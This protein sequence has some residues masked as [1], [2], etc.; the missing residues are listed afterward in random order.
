MSKL[1]AGV[2]AAAVILTLGACSAETE[3]T[4]ES[5]TWTI[6]T[7][8]IA[9]TNLEPYMMEDLDELGQAG[10]SDALNLV[11][12]VDRSADYGD[13]PVLGLDGWVGGKLLELSD[14]GAT[15]LEDLGDVNTGDPQV[16]SDFIANGIKDYPADHYG[17]I[18]SDHGASWPGVGGDESF[19]DDGLDLFEINEAI[20]GGIEGGGI[21]KLDLLG[22]DACLMATYEVASTLAPL[23]DRLLASQELEPGHGWDYS[24]LSFV[25]ENGGANVDDIGA[26]IIDGFQAQAVEQEDESE[27]TLSLTDLTKMPAVDA[28]LADFSSQLIERV[29]GVAPTVGRTLA[30]TLGFG[31]SPDPDSD[32]FMTD[33]GILAGEIG[34]D[35]LDVS[36]AAD[37]LVRAINDAVIN[38]VDGQ[39]TAGATGLSIYFPPQAVYYTQDYDEIVTDGQWIEFLQAYYGAGDGID[40]GDKPVSTGD[41]EIEF[42][43]DGLYISGFFGVP[44]GNVSQTYIRYGTVEADGSTTFLGQEQA[45]IDDAGNASGFFDLTTMEITDGEDTAPA[46]LE[47]TYDEDQGINTFDVP[48]AYYEPGE[49]DE[50]VDVTLSITLDEDW[51]VLTETYYQYNED[52][53]TYGELST[54]ADGIIVPQLLSVASDGT[55]TWF[56]TTETG[57][58]ADLPNLQYTFPTLASGTVLYIELAVVDFGG[59]I[60]KVSATVTIP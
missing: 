40:E 2:A 3:S 37:T 41:A 13:D 33:L 22:F 32:S 5:G 38:K 8:S 36:D 26:A 35:A 6:L 1:I 12:L 18:I 20:A 52:L 24:A 23:A 10:G 34:V 11:A 45:E 27:I 48:L 19:D 46:Y 39:A 25:G 47:L 54:E 7:Y 57:L 53:Q 49:G 31:T 51:N 28:A 50:Y 60:A 29:D 9:D 58:Y 17:L 42:A 14:G 43:D 30:Q 16:L 4:A 59:N 21:D 55:Q 56:G 15:E 44:A